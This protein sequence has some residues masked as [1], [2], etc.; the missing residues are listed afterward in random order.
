[1]Y[2]TKT[3]K[4]CL[5]ELN[6]NEKGLSASEVSERTKIYGK[7]I[8]YVKGEPIWKKILKP[9]ANI[10]MLILFIAA[11]V[12]LLHEDYADSLIIL[13]IIFINAMI[14]YV[15]SFSTE[16]ILKALSEH[17]KNKVNVYREK[18]II[19][20]DLADLVPGDVLKLSEGEKIPAD[21]RVIESNSF[22][23]DESQL[24]G[25]SFPINKQTDPIDSDKEVYEQTNMIFQGSFVIGGSAVALVVATGNNTEFGK[26]AKLSTPKTDVSPVQK[27]I[28]NLIS[29]II[30]AVMIIAIVA[31]VLSI[32]R[33]MDFAD[34]LKYVLALSVSA[35]PESL[36]VAITVILV[37]GIRR[38]AKKHSL[39]KNTSAI[40]TIGALTVIATDKTGTLTQNKLTLRQIWSLGD[41]EDQLLR[42]LRMSVNL[43]ESA[44]GDPLDIAITDYV[45]SI[46]EDYKGH[47][48]MTKL[49]F[50]QEFSMSGNVFKSG[51]QLDLFIKGSP[52]S[53]LSRSRLSVGEHSKAMQQLHTMA[54]NGLR[55]IALAHVKNIQKD[56]TF[57]S[58]DDLDVVFDGLIAVSDVLRLEAKESI[59]IAKDAGIKVCMITGDHFET[60]FHIGKEL[61]LVHNKNQVFDCKKMKDLSDKE[62]S[63]II[64]NINVFSRVTPENKYRILT[65]LKKNNIVAMTGDGVNDVPALVKSHIGIA[66]GS[67]A[68][69]AKDA[70]DI[71]LLDNNFTSIICAI[72]EGRT[73]YANIKR[74]VAYLLSTNA[75]EMLV[76]ICAL[77]I[78]VPIPLL[79][80]QILW[81]N[82]VTDTCLVIPLGLE[83][84]RRHNMNQTPQRPDGPLFSKF[85]ISRII[86]VSIIM[87]AVTLSVYMYMLQD[88]PHDYA[89]TVAFQTLV[90]MQ[91]ISAFCYRSDYESFFGNIKRFSLGFYIGLFIAVLMQV[92]ALFSPLG[93]LLHLSPVAIN[94]IAISTLI[95]IIV[96]LL[97]IE[98]HK[99]IGR[100]YFKK[101]SKNK[102]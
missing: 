56:I 67:G 45:K 17:E 64:D 69:I 100:R 90:V 5:E 9:F 50:N 3:V 15:Q 32:Y 75:G 91:W 53:I 94:D 12:S 95:A 98:A 49:P 34:G 68:S 36:P 97:F 88:K 10:L 54:G 31:F 20:V 4:K 99:F 2:Y 62:L 77:I 19:E 80:V 81:V 71:I 7:N 13:S 21:A 46:A 6:T 26:L 29:T 85:M 73:I 41:S 28:D 44:T 92:I 93:D 23:V 33:G 72:N 42:T 37:L 86:L 40:E 47:I 14:Y 61:G 48:L 35:V 51:D 11:G 78:G 18:T 57:E 30:K 87:A 89:R 38:M 82:L 84:S 27:K 52:E 22:R 96:P 16:R 63:K 25:E 66:M 70:G 8:I 101:G 76:A 39:V 102:I 58:I 59:S 65:L 55:V 74:M 60:S 43:S 24:T 1:M 79:P 83:P